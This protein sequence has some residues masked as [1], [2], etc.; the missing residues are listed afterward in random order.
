MEADASLTIYRKAADS[1]KST[2]AHLQCV[3]LMKFSLDFYQ[4]I[5]MFCAAIEY[6]E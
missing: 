1:H 5:E 3:F 2:Q 4:I 6:A